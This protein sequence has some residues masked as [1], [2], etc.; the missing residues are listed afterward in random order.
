MSYDVI[1]LQNMMLA[2]AGDDEHVQ[3]YDL[4]A[5]KC[6]CEFKAHENRCVLLNMLKFCLLLF[7]L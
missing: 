4:T 5:E 3:V 1:P 7:L 2:V 6:I